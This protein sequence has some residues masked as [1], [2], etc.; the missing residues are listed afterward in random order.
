MFVLYNSLL[1]YEIDLM[2]VSLN[3]FSKCYDFHLQLGKIE[4]VH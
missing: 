4:D 1:N 3:Y 2:W